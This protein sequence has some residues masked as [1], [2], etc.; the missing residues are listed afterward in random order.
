MNVYSVQFQYFKKIYCILFIL[1]VSI[2]VHAQYE[3]YTEIGLAGGTS[4]YL[5][6]LNKSHFDYSQVAGGLVIRKNIDRRISYKAELLLLQLRGDDRRKDND[7]VALS[8]QLHFK[9]PIH[10]LSGQI[11]FNFLPYEIGN[12]LY[13]WTPFL[14]TGVSIFHFNPKAESKNGK[15]VA[16][17][18][19]GTEG[20]GTTAV[21]DLK[22]YPLIQFSIP[23]G[24]GIKIAVNEY[25]NIILEYGIR[26]TFTD[27]VDDVSTLYPGSAVLIPENGVLSAEMSDP[28][29][30]Q[31]AKKER[32]DDTRKDWYSF[33]GITLSF[34][35]ANNTIGCDY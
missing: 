34:K 3:P 10:E 15:W 20:Q 28:T 13:T 32:G 29:G 5:G 24:G 17:Q 26:K 23:M 14:F 8:R 6:D 19:L 2:S 21:P 1:L 4:Y 11:E 30:I 18:P 7:T 31:I 33:A 12:P 9:T 22:K 27:Y 16:L 25:F 35:L